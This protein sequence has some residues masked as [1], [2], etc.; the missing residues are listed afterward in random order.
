MTTSIELATSVTEL[1]LETKIA[2]QLGSQTS[3]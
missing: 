3:I 2:L 1:K